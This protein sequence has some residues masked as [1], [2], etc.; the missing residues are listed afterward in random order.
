MPLWQEL[1]LLLIVAF[2]LAVLIRTFLLQAFYIPSSSMETTLLIGDRVLVNKIVY[3]MRDPARG[4]VIVFRGTDRWAP[5]VRETPGTGFLAKAGRTAGDLVGLAQPSEKDYIKRVIGLPGDTVQCCDEQGRVTV[6]GKP[7]NEAAYLPEEMDSPLDAPATPG[8]CGPRLFDAV[9]V[10]A[11]QLFVMGDYRAV[12]QDSRCQGPVP[13]ENVIGRAIAVAW[14]SN[15]WHGLPALTSFEGT[16]TALG[17]VPVEKKSDT[18]AGWVLVVPI[19][20]GLVIPARSRRLSWPW[21]R[22][23][24]E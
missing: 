19:L 16:A 21:Q 8:A 14:P 18:G 23:L 12:S 22:R 13:L 5:E 6:N 24:L 4:E 3:D 20:A 1:P 11:G 9:T 17:P 2:C 15:R 7:L 10:P